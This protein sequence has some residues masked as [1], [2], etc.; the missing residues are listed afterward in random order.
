MTDTLEQKEKQNIQPAS[1]VRCRDHPE[2]RKKD[3]IE[4]DNLKYNKNY[5]VLVLK[6]DED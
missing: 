5:Q 3:K 2:Q 6:H 4:R 1:I